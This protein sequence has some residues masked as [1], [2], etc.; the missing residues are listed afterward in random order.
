MRRKTSSNNKLPLQVTSR[1]CRSSVISQQ[2]SVRWMT[3]AGILCT[4]RRSNLRSRSWRRC[5][6]VGK[7]SNILFDSLKRC[8]VRRCCW[9]R[10]CSGLY[11]QL[12]TASQSA[13]SAGPRLNVTDVQ[14]P[15][16]TILLL[17]NVK[18]KHFILATRLICISVQLPR[19][20]VM[21]K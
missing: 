15:T 17:Q 14:R 3:A 6:T 8:E 20:A 7:R 16:T 2:P 11:E 10:F 1:L 21:I 13:S 4:E 5:C 12:Q 18:F 19:Q 9:C